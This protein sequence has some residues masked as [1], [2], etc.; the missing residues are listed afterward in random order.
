MKFLILPCLFL[1]HRILP[2]LALSCLALSCLTLL[3]RLPG[4]EARRG[5]RKL[6]KKPAILDTPIGHLSGALARVCPTAVQQSL[7]AFAARHA[8]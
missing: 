5:L 7:E 2:C 4:I 1:P 6:A 8:A 3:G